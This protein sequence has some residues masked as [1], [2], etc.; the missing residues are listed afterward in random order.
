MPQDRVFEQVW[1]PEDARQA[2]RDAAKH[3]GERGYPPVRTRDS[4]RTCGGCGAWPLEPCEPSCVDMRDAFDDFRYAV[5][6]RYRPGGMRPRRARAIGY[7]MVA[8]G[9]LVLF[10]SAAVLFVAAVPR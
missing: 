5:S 9:V 6:D 1:K 2:A 4:Q 3:T 7:A 10:L 8:V